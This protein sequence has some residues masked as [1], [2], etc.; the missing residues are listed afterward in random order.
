MHYE[1]EC[2][3]DMLAV[4]GACGP[5]QWASVQRY[6]E[7][8]RPVLCIDVGYF[9]RDALFAEHRQVKIV[10]NDPHPEH[11]PP[12]RPDRFDRLGIPLRNVAN[13]DGPV[14]VAGMGQKSRRWLYG[15]SDPRWELDTIER[16]RE[17]GNPVIYRPK[18]RNGEQ[19]PGVVS[20]GRR[21]S[22]IEQLLN[23]AALAISRH[24]N[25]C[26]V[27]AV[28]AGVPAVVET[29]PGVNL[30][31][32][33]LRIVHRSPDERLDY[34]RRLA[35]WSWSLTELQRGDHWDWILNHCG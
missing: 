18:H 7:T 31:P 2:D 4:W 3:A 21:E 13:S 26:H 34:L 27:D 23:G 10:L 19:L 29:G 20:V 28:L 8:C 17:L 9:R 16:A 35:W 25:V 22:G 12:A 30:W 1:A 32:R 33:D 11:L 6:R 14:I 24:S 5:R 15:M